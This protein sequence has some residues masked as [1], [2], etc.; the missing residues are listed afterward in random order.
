MLG[1]KFSSILPKLN[2]YCICFCKLKEQ[3][4]T[5]LEHPLYNNWFQLLFQLKIKN[6]K[7]KNWDLV[8]AIIHTCAITPNIWVFSTDKLC[9]VATLEPSKLFQYLFKPKCCSKNLLV[10]C[11][12][13]I[14]QYIS[15]RMDKVSP[16]KTNHLVGNLFPVFYQD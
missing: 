2:H 6:K 13:V 12:C 3:Y 5:Y 1:Y 8:N 15:S 14:L 7:E 9:I 4:P 10:V 16:C 11:I